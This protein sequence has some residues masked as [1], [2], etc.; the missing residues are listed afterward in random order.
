ML[1]KVGTTSRLA[2][3]TELQYIHENLQNP[4]SP[5]HLMVISHNQAGNHILFG[6]SYG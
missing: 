2:R 1:A 4:T 6:L 5:R 3:A